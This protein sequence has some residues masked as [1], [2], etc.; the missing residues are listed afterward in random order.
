[1]EQKGIVETNIN[2]SEAK[3]NWKDFGKR[4]AA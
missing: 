1:M 3:L 2:N 4:C